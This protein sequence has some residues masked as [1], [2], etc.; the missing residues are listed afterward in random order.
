MKNNKTFTKIRK[1]C[2]VCN[3]ITTF[4]IETW[5]STCLNCDTKFDDDAEDLFGEIDEAVE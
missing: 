3:K 5:V 1:R 4:I 2:E